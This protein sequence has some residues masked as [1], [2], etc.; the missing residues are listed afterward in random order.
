MQFSSHSNE[1]L[2]AD[3]TLSAMFHST[4]SQTAYSNPE[5]DQ[6]VDAA[7]TETDLAKRA[8]DYNQAVQI[9]YDD[10]VVG[11]LLNLKDIYGMTTRVEWTPRVDGKMIVNEMKLTP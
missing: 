9:A 5:F 8:E 7:R 2:D 10:A 4:G 6:L 3:R 11:F 1:L